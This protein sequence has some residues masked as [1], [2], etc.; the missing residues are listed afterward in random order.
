MSTI[1]RTAWG[2]TS[3]TA[4]RHSTQPRAEP[5][6]LI[7]KEVPSVPATPLESRPNGFTRRMASARPG[8]W[9]SRTERVPSG[10]WSLGPNPV[11]PV[12]TIRPWKPSASRRSV[13]AA[14]ARTVPPSTIAP[15]TSSRPIEKASGAETAARHGVHTGRVQTCDAVLDEDYFLKAIAAGEARRRRMMA[16]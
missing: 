2:T 3:A 1:R 8:A 9:R 7:I 11:P 6:V 12:V 10:V 13:A 5:G 16:S 14:S 15:T 4:S